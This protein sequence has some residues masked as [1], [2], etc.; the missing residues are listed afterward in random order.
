MLNLFNKKEKFYTS[1]DELPIY[2]WF[3]IKSENNLKWLQKGSD[4]LLTKKNTQKAI[5]IF[6]LIQDE[7]IKSFGINEEYKYVLEKQRDLLILKSDLILQEDTSLLTFIE[8]AEK[9]LELISSDDK[10][11]PNGINDGKVNIEKYLGFKIDLKTTTVLEYYSYV[12][13]IK[14]TNKQKKQIANGY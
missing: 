7:F 1:I 14:K 10:Q 3:K 5:A 13:D 6:D 2:N 4:Y 9:E 11:S 8:I 12:E